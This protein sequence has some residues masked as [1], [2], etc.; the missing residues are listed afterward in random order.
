MKRLLSLAVFISCVLV[1]SSKIIGDVNG[2]EKISAADVATLISYLIDDNIQYDSRLADVDENGI[3]DNGDVT[4]L[5][6]IILGLREAKQLVE[7]DVDALIIKYADEGATYQ[8]PE[9]WMPYVTVTVNGTDVTV[10]NTNATEEYVT[11]LSGSCTDGSFIYNGSF[12]TSLM[13]NGLS[14]TNQRG[15]C[16]DI[17][18]G[19]RVSLQLA[20]GT[21][22]TLADGTAGK[23][24]L[25]C[26]GHLEIS[27]GGSLTVTGNVKH[28]ISAKEY[29]EVKKS[30]G[31]IKIASAQSDGIHAEQYFKMNGGTIVMRNIA[32]DGI[33]AE[34]KLLGDELDGQL[35]VN[36]GTIDIAL[37]GDDVA[38]LKSDSLLTI[39]GGSITIVS[40]GNDVKAL[41]SKADILVTD[42][43]LSVTQSGG[44]LVSEVTDADGAVTYD[45][46]YSTAV[47]ADGKITVSGGTVTVSSSADG[48]RGLNATG[49]IDI[50]GGMLDITADGGGGALD[51]STAGSSSSTA[52][53]YRL[54][55]SLPTTNSGGYQPGGQQSAWKNV[56]LYD[57]SNTLVA[58]LSQQQSFTVNGQTTTFYYYD[59]GTATTGTYY[60]QSDSYTSGGGPGGGRVYNIRSAN[61][62]LSLTGSDAFYAISN[63]YSTSGSTRTYTINNVTSTYAGASSAAE[64]GETYKAFC[65]KSD[66]DITITGGTITLSHSGTMSKG[67]KADGSV[68]ISGGTVS[69]IAAGDYMIIG[70]DPTYST[71]IKC[72]TYSGSD[73]E[74]TILAT[75]SASHGISADATLTITGGTYD[76]TLSGDGATYSGNGDTEGAGSK[77][78]KSDADML[79]QG[80]T[81]T[82][83]SSARGGKGIKVGD[84]NVSGASGAHLIIGSATEVGRGPSLT[85]A[86]TGSYLATES[87]GGGWGGGPMDEGFVG[88]CKA[89]KCMGPVDVYGGT[90][91]LST[92]S[93]GAEGLESKSIITVHGGTLES[94]TYDDAINA[95]STITF[96][97]G[98]VWAHA[99]NNDA[100]DSNDGTTGIVINDGVVIASGA[101][102]PEEGFDCDNAAFVLN[103]GVVIGTGGSQGGGGSSGGQP[104]NA[105]QPYVTLSSVSLTSGTYLSLKSSSGSVICSYRIPHTTSSAQVLMSAPQL[106]SGSNATIVYGS[107]SISN[108]D[109]SLWEGGY[110]TGATLTGGT[111]VNVTAKT[112]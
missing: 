67:I 43:T 29:I 71:A 61:I 102:S 109:V 83:N 10:T 103:G 34:A 75:G 22:N 60:L 32:G 70:T 42:G 64:E 76:I 86:T 94:D 100:I 23:A 88:S 73:G 31:I 81:I 68:T 48:G 41:K 108:P 2:D 47:K 98:N 15:C 20:D 63:S 93:N 72:N 55:V 91:R 3:V 69:D 6:E 84:S 97:G 45:P 79:L 21:V 106:S 89:V 16:I 66:G 80:G 85:V 95:A 90:I 24:A 78:L 25:F 99:S 8:L 54:Y 7:D 112:R 1:A 77:A 39:G 59:F 46:S 51:L 62:S 50:E 30:A 74:V 49:R 17:E 36:G 107:S 58:Q 35:I 96:D 40:T 92:K 19:K 33:Q 65:L 28:A 14:L 5:V 12:K 101:N 4:A 26:K 87:S 37:A 56:Y 111:S 44:Y 13:L 110:T 38:A 57:S 53:S 18:D 11:V 27:G 9:A 52:S 82:I 104:T 105:S